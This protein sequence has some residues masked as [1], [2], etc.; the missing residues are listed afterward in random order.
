MPSLS[1]YLFLVKKKVSKKGV[2]HFICWISFR[3]NVH[4]SNAAKFGEKKGLGIG[5]GMGT[6]QI[7]ML[8]NYAL[9]L[10]YVISDK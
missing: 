10:W 6:F 8:S 5:I 1:F 4:L 7:C 2:I 3:Y 9:S